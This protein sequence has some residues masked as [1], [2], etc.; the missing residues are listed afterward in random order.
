MKA[1]KP[2]VDLIYVC[3]RFKNRY[4]KSHI[5]IFTGKIFDFGKNAKNNYEQIKNSSEVFSV[6][7]NHCDI[8]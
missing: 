7:F 5:S 4:K 8:I 1:F 2:H 3:T 6:I